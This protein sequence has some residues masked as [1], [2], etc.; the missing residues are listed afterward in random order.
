MSSYYWE[1]GVKYLIQKIQVQYKK[2]PY[3]WDNREKL[4][5][6]YYYLDSVKSI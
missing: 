6:D 4:I 5:K 3:H 1:N 2:I